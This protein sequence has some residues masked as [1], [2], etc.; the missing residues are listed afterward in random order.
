MSLLISSI[1]LSFSIKE[2]KKNVGLRFTNRFGYGTTHQEMSFIQP[3]RR[4]DFD[5][6]KKTL[7]VLKKCVALHDLI[8]TR[9]VIR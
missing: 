6:Y 3:E 1:S 5:F 9:D 2:T 7:K 4:A 8:F